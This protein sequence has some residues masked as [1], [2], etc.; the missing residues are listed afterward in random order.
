MVLKRLVPCL[1]CSNRRDLGASTGLVC[2]FVKR[3]TLTAGVSA[4]PQHTGVTYL[5]SLLKRTVRGFH[6]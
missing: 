1:F 3:S 2:F 4:V 5:S 6:S